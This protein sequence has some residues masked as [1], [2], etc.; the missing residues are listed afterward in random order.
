[1]R[2]FREMRVL[3]AQFRQARR[4][5]KASMRALNQKVESLRVEQE[6]RAFTTVSVPRQPSNAQNLH[7]FLGQCTTTTP[8]AVERAFAEMG[9]EN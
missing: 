5:E 3:L 7:R 9:D 1:M 8:E 2:W 4:D 6:S